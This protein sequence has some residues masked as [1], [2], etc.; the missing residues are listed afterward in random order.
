M[1]T[2]KFY[3]VVLLK[4]MSSSSITCKDLSRNETVQ[5]RYV[6]NKMYKEGKAIS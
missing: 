1:P 5:L 3:W 4:N 2:D 6:G